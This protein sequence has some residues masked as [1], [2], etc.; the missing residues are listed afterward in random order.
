M[1]DVECK[2]KRALHVL[3][4]PNRST[5]QEFKIPIFISYSAKKDPVI[6]KYLKE[7]EKI[8]KCFIDNEFLDVILE[9]YCN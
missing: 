6:K 9:G 8:K 3:E 7:R 1:K 4:Q 2:G 5:L